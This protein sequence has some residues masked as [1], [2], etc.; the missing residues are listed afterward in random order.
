MGKAYNENPKFY[1]KKRSYFTTMFIAIADR[2]Q[3]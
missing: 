1:L 3:L 2:S